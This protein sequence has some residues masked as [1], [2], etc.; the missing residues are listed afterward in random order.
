[1]EGSHLAGGSR[2][3]GLHWHNHPELSEVAGYSSR[4]E[5]VEE[6]KQGSFWF[7]LRT[8][9]HEENK[10]PKASC[11][12]GYENIPTTAPPPGDVPE[13]QGWNISEGRILADDP[14]AGPTAP[15]EVH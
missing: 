6:A 4:Q 8:T 15:V 3:Q 9:R 7:W 14:A 1:M 11:R 10:D 2:L 5:L 13:L 12:E